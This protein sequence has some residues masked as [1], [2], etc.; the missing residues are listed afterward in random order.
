MRKVAT[1]DF[2]VEACH[3]KISPKDEYIA[4]AHNGVIRKLKVLNWRMHYYH[5]QY[6]LL[7]AIPD[8]QNLY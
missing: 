4:M 5:P 8:A 3:I 6:H 1:Q 2:Q 7:V